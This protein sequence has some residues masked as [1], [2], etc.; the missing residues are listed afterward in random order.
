[1]SG[2]LGG[3]VEFVVPTTG[4]TWGFEVAPVIVILG[5]RLLGGCV[6][7]RWDCETCRSS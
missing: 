6:D 1:M 5:V 7:V 2:W 3:R 4:Q